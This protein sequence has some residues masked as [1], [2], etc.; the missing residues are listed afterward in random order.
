MSK[1][2]YRINTSGIGSFLSRLTMPAVAGTM[3]SGAVYLHIQ[4]EAKQSEEA[5]ARQE[6]VDRTVIDATVAGPGQMTMT[7]GGLKYIFDFESGRVF[8]DAGFEQTS[9]E[10]SEFANDE[11]VNLVKKR[12]CEAPEG[13]PRLEAFICK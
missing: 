9:M 13:Q 10:I 5:E 1:S 7:R 3:L 8:V 2:G 11:L 12:G 6:F 4:K